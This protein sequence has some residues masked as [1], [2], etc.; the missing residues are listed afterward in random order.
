MSHPSI[1]TQMDIDTSNHT[2]QPK[3]YGLD[4]DTSQAA[5][6]RCKS[7]SHI[8]RWVC[9]TCM[10][11]HKYSMCASSSVMQHHNMQHRCFAVCSDAA[12]MVIAPSVSCYFSLQY[13]TT[14]LPI[15][16]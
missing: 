8:C 2:N 12:P 6:E 7:F 3:Q 9:L 11:P 5:S 13:C 16:S 15:L 14:L 1:S 10:L 4:K